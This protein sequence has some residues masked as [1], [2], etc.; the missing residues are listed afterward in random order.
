[1][2]IAGFQTDP[3]YHL[4]I[5][6]GFVTEKPLQGKSRYRGRAE[7]YEK[8]MTEHLTLLSQRW[9][10]TYARSSLRF[11]PN[12]PI[13]AWIIGADDEAW[14]E[15]GPSDLFKLIAQDNLKPNYRVMIVAQP[16]PAN[17]F[18]PIN[19]HARSVG[20]LKQVRRGHDDE[21]QFQRS[22][23]LLLGMM[24]D[25]YGKFRYQPSPVLSRLGVPYEFSG[26]GSGTNESGISA[27]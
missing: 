11:S 3:S 12:A 17:C 6:D 7:R 9:R 26:S 24:D 5:V 16:R 8:L 14:L 20:I 23:R 27:T 1:M 21:R 13:H 10:T 18:V 22:A 15:R 25:R 4:H 2:G 19:R